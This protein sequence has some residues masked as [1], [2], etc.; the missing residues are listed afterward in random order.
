MML[1]EAIITTNPRCP[2]HQG[3]KAP[4]LPA[5]LPRS[6]LDRET[7]ACS[8]NRC[9]GWECSRLTTV[10]VMMAT[11]NQPHTA[12]TGPPLLMAMLSDP[13]DSNMLQ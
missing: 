1:P 6:C 9:K 7:D 10:M 3:Q 8:A 4:E 5:A 13:A 12:A 2:V 11:Q